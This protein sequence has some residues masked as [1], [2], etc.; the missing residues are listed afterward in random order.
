MGSLVSTAVE[1]YFALVTA[2]EADAFVQLFAD[3]AEV[4]DPVGA[5]TLLGPG[6]MAKFHGRLHRAW[7]RLAMTEVERFERGNR[8]AVRWTASGLSAGGKAIAFDGIN[9]FDV[10]EDGKITRLS[11]YWDFD[12]VVA[13]F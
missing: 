10:G 11:A 4:E 7:Q 9:T 2:P 8:A 3:D 1:R 12:G 6:G 13:Q 5:P